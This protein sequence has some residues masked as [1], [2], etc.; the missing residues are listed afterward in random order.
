MVCSRATR[1][2]W[3]DRPLAKSNKSPIDGRPTRAEAVAALHSAVRFGSRNDAGFTGR[4]DGAEYWRT[5]C[6]N[7]EGGDRV[8]ASAV[9]VQRRQHHNDKYLVG[10]CRRCGGQHPCGEQR[11]ARGA[12]EGGR[13]SARARSCGHHCGAKEEGREGECAPVRVA[14]VLLR[15][16]DPLEVRRGCHSAAAY[17]LFSQLHF[18]FLIQINPTVR[19]C[20][21]QDSSA[22]GSRSARRSQ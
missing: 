4:A 6:R 9:S 10:D 11:N 8:R 20:D 19:V 2:A 18:I 3:L 17:T 7:A 5:G 16:R 14:S 1:E 15:D 13:H 21:A 22:G 12:S